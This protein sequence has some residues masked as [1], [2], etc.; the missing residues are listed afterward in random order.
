[1]VNP[2]TPTLSMRFGSAAEP[3]LQDLAAE[4]LGVKVRMSSRTF[5]HPRVR[6]CATPDAYIVADH[7]PVV[8]MNGWDRA[9]VEFKLSFSQ[10]RWSHGLPPD[11]EWQAGHRWPVRTGA[12][13]WSTC[14]AAAS[15]CSWSIVTGARNEP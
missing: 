13:S 7:G 10:H 2:R 14:S 9:L 15:T 5:E 8:T 6:L 3:I 11:V 12:R 1:M 4:R